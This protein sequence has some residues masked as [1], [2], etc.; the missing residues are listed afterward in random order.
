MKKGK[1]MAKKNR[2]FLLDRHGGRE[3]ITRAMYSPQSYR[4]ENAKQGN[5]KRWSPV[6]AIILGLLIAYAVHNYTS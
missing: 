5:A 4:R 2:E 6:G 3:K 1:T